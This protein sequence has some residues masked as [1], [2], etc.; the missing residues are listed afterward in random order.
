MSKETP[1]I[2]QVE[3][4]L[5]TESSVSAPESAPE[6]VIPEAMIP[7]SPDE[8]TPNAMM[9]SFSSE[10]LDIPDEEYEVYQEPEPDVEVDLESFDLL[11]IADPNFPVLDMGRAEVY[12]GPATLR[13]FTKLVDGLDTEGDVGM[14]KGLGLWMLARHEEAVAQ[15]SAYVADDVAAFTLAR[16]L[17]VLARWEEAHKIYV[18]LT[19][20]YPEERRPRL[21]MLETQLELGLA[22]GDTEAAANEL[23]AAI[24]AAPASFHNGP[25][26]HYLTGRSNELQRNWEEA[27]DGYADAR[28][29]DPANRENLF[30]LAHLAERFGLDHVALE[31]YENLAGMLPI[32]TAVLMNMGVLYEDLGRDQD[33][34]AC[35]ETVTRHDPLNARARRYL[36]DARAAIDMYYDEDQERMEDRLNQ[37]LRI[38]ITDFELSVRARNC[39]NRMNI[40]TIGDLV[41]RTEQE[42]LS[43]K[44]FGETSLKEIKEILT[45][46]GLRLGMSHDEAVSSVES[47]TDVVAPVSTD[48]DD[49]NNRSLAELNLSI[50]ARRTVETLGCLTFGDVLKHSSDE[51][52][53]MPNF[54]V[55]SL[56]ELKAKL[57]E[58]GLGLRGDTV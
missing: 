31:A 29:Q 24:E 39:L 1:E 7:E 53:G 50:R 12:A 19:E 55:T 30:R 32:E 20:K 8:E 33:A 21:G 56:N 27:L 23:E 5:E 57:S 11:G 34:A 22:K 14:R 51:L 28:E 26:H 13:T 18:T 25:E 6:T 44:N 35:Y 37:V 54:G 48:P 36:L 42:L 4:N 52:L 46:K 38:P 3:T 9:D 2:P 40:N 15:L 47:S 41:G 16:A 49:I 43:Y 58:V 45:S 17:C 10:D